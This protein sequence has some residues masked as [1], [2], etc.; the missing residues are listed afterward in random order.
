MPNTLEDTQTHTHK[1][2][3]VIH[4]DARLSVAPA[5]HAVHAGTGKEARVI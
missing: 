3:T 1:P 5:A 2:L 4:Y